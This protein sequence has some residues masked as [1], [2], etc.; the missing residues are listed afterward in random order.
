MSFRK[1]DVRFFNQTHKFC[2]G[3]DAQLLHCPAAMD[4]YCLFR[5]AQF[6][7]NLFVQHT[8]DHQ[9][10]HLE[11]P[12]RQQIKKLARVIPSRGALPFLGRAQQGP[13]DTL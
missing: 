1:R 13:V 10:H 9:L 2:N 7:G 6:S 12:R 3:S 4:F 5:G 8:R 11:L